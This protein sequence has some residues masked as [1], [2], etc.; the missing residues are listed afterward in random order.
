MTITNGGSIV[1]FRDITKAFPGVLALDSVSFEIRKGEVHAL[2]GENGAGKST[3]IKILSG[4]EQKDSGKILCNGVE[5]SIA[6]PSAAF[7]LG[8]T[9]IYQELPLAPA[10]SVS[11][12]VFL[13]Q[14][15]RKNG[16]LSRAE[17][18]RAVREFFREFGIEVDP[19]TPVERLSVSMQQITAIIKAMMKEARLFIMDEPTATLGEH[20]VARLFDFIGKLKTRNISV[21]YISHRMD[22]IFGIAD[23]VTVLKD[24]RCMGTREVDE[25]SRGEL[26]TLMSGKKIDDMASAHR[27][28]EHGVD[29][30]EVLEVRGLCYEDRLS[31]ISFALRKGEILGITGLVGAG[32][33]ELLKC[34]YGLLE[35]TGGEIV[36]HG[37]PAGRR[38]RRGARGPGRPGRIASDAFA[39]GLVPEDR[40]R[41]GLFLELEVLKNITI[42]S[43]GF[44]TRLSYI[45]KKKETALAEK[46]LR[47]LDIKARSLHQQVQ[48]LSGGNQQKVILSRWLSS[49]KKILLMDE[50]TRGVDVMAKSEIY[51]LMGRLAEQQI[52]IVFSSSDVAEVLGISDRLATM[53]NGRIVQVYE[54]EDFDKEKV[55]HDILFD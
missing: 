36:V 51:K 34:I 55:L 35:P 20:E 23:R 50:P 8:I 47:D 19:K 41:E 7:D 40:K 37:I 24:G 49:R 45:M 17:Q 28:A 30:A 33:T 25:I 16:F 29:E 5:V 43:L 27:A 54:R 11:D 38:G 1:E 6:N 48:F 44:L 15:I 9:S 13:G 12:N 18:Q 53:R 39:F 42:S 22:E 21:L 4:V 3:L 14:E 32:K 26:I 46:S 52:S 10:L 31:G 2:V